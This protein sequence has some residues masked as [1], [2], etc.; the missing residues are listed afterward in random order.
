MQ[1]SDFNQYLIKPDQ[2]SELSQISSDPWDDIPVSKIEAN[3]ELY[4]LQKRLSDLQQRF[5]VDRRKKLLVV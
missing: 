2:N 4:I 1:L 3:E 5:F